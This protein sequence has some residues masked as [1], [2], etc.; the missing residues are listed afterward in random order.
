MAL[1]ASDLGDVVPAFLATH[2]AAGAI[3]VLS[4]MAALALRKGERAHRTAGAVFVLSMIVMGLSAAYLA[5]RINS[6]TLAGGVFAVYLVA[7]SWLTVKAAN[8]LAGGWSIAAL[9]F[10][11]GIAALEL[12]LGWRALNAPDGTLFGY[13]PPPYLIMGSVAALAALM[14]LKVLAMGGITG[15][16]RI[17]RHL[18][19]MCFGL[20]IALG[21]FATQGL[22][23]ILPQE[24]KGTALH[25]A[26]VF[27]PGL[28]VILLMIWWLIRVRFTGWGRRLAEPS[29][30]AA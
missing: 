2:I 15:P 16:A 14:D 1:H 27:G 26:L 7:T 22:R 17:A 11:T 21:S 30:L 20:F 23:H 19:R 9:A 25:W 28:V 6:I 3:A 18:W 10:I 5:Y 8:G 4:G 12:W 24:L 29:A 13:P